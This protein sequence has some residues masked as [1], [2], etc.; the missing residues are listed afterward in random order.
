M[1]S[2]SSIQLSR[3][4][5]S[6]VFQCRFSTNIQV[7]AMASQPFLHAGPASSDGKTCLV[8]VFSIMCFAIWHADCTHACV[9]MCCLLLHLAELWHVLLLFQVPGHGA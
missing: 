1:H 2:V 4:A 6:P 7:L 9:H 5:T 8:S 3:W